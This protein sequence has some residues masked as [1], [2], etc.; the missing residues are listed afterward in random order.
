MNHV[1]I[2]IIQV[3]DRDVSNM[4]SFQRMRIVNQAFCTCLTASMQTCIL[5]VL[6]ANFRQAGHYNK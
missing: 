5:E 2:F 4:Y 1:N 3:D 6:L